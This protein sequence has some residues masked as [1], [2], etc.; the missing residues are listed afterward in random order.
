MLL[1]RGD[2]AVPELALDEDQ[3]MAGREPGRRGGVAQ[4]VQRHVAQAGVL[5]CRLVPVVD[6]LAVRR[7]RLGAAGVAS[8][9][10][11]RAEEEPV[12]VGRRGAVVV[13]SARQRR[14]EPRA[15]LDRAEALALRRLR[16]LAAGGRAGGRCERRRRRGR[17]RPKR[18]RAPR[19]SGRRCRSGTPRAGGSARRTRRGSAR[20]RRVGGSRARSARPAAP[21]RTVHGLRRQQPAATASLSAT[22]RHVR[23][24]LTVFGASSPASTSSTISASQRAHA[25]PR[26]CAR[27]AGRRSTAAAACGRA[28]RSPSS[29]PVRHVRPP[30]LEQPRPERRRTSR[31]RRVTS[32]RS[33]DSTQ[34]AGARS[35]RRAGS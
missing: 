14:D 27:A 26:R 3:R 10:R 31:G 21:A 9:A 7:H 19:R 11:R 34:R 17:G 28:S 13:C 12:V 29:V 1:G 24:L 23:A 30:L 6:G 33:I 15:D 25:A 5:E 18:T 4:R 16:V 32:P 8:A 22:D 35:R 20:S 2:R